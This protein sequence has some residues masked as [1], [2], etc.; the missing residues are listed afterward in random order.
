ML[1]FANDVMKF[2]L[3]HPGLF[4]A[5][6]IWYLLVFLWVVI[7]EL[8]AAVIF[9]TMFLIVGISLVNTDIGFGKLFC[10]Y[11]G[12]FIIILVIFKHEEWVNKEENLTWT[13]VLTRFSFCVFASAALVLLVNMNKS[14]VYAYMG[15]IELLEYNNPEMANVYY[16][17]AKEEKVEYPEMYYRRQSVQIRLGKYQD[18]IEDVNKAIEFDSTFI[19]FYKHK[20]LLEINFGDNKT[21]LATLDFIL[22]HYIKLFNKYGD[23]YREKIS[24]IYFYRAVVLSKLKQYEESYISIELAIHYC[25]VFPAAHEQKSLI[26]KQLGKL[27]EAKMA[28]GLAKELTKNKQNI[29]PDLDPVLYWRD[30][31]LKKN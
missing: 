5:I 15:D 27:E 8:F 14:Y 21:A 25:Y 31:E 16:E 1:D 28:F 3:S 18:A 9:G 17:L 4:M 20:A 29:E 12:F 2:L 30:K 10:V 11:M 7:K 13:I 6:G 22:N 23:I 26:L 24:N 19:P